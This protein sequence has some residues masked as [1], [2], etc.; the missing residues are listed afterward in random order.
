MIRG[1]EE[2]FEQVKSRFKIDVT[3]ICEF[4]MLGFLRINPELIKQIKIT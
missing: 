2:V 4:F 1:P 3:T